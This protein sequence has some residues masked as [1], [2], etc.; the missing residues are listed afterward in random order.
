MTTRTRNNGRMAER[1]TTGL[2]LLLSAE[3]R[4]LLMKTASMTNDLLSTKVSQASVIRRAIRVYHDHLEAQQLKLALGGDLPDFNTFLRTE[5]LAVYRANDIP[6]D[7]VDPAKEYERRSEVEVKAL[8]EA[9]RGMTP[10]QIREFIRRP[11]TE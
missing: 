2:T 7:G 10:E 4:R 1:G 11:K 9:T 5:K 8:W 6:L 3:D